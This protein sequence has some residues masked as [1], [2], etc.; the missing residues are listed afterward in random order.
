LLSGCGC[1]VTKANTTHRLRL[2]KTSHS[3]Q[4]SI[5][6]TLPDLYTDAVYRM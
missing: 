5:S 2:E 3:E 1:T 4:A 6:F